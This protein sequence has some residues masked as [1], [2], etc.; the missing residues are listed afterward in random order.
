VGDVD[1]DG[2]PDL[3]VS[4]NGGP[5]ALLR[6]EGAGRNHWLALRLRGTKS[7]R[8]GIGTRVV[9][10]A[11]GRAQTGWVRSGSSYCSANE[12][13]ARFGLGGAT[14]ADRIDLYWPGGATQTLRNVPADQ[15]LSV[16]EP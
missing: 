12:L 1:S 15:L 11:A 3:L 8:D 14:R 16:T 10:N 7:N 13:V 2:D 6:N 9:L 5:A 4:A